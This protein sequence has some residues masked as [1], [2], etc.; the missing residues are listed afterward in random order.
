MGLAGE[1]TA[2]LNVEGPG[3]KPAAELSV[4]WDGPSLVMSGKDGKVTWRAP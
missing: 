4:A 2:Y 3:E 1:D